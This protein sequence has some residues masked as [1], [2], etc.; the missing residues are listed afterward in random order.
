MTAPLPDLPVAQ[1][2][3]PPA[4]PAATAGPEIRSYDNE[5]PAFAE[6]ELERLYECLMSTLARFDIYAAAPGAS[7]YVV[8]E[9][10]QVTTLF[11]FRHERN[12]VIVYNEQ[13]PL[14]AAD[15]RR[16]A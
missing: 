15:I 1:C 16:F 8:R 9:H 14:A 10:G 11:L 4:A 7:T 13:M 2:L 6:A 3:A 5:V 12:Q